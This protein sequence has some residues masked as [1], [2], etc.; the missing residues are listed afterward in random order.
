MPRE[1]DVETYLGACVRTLGGVA[2]KFTSPG[3]RSVPD[4]HV[5]LPGAVEFYVEC[6]APG[7]K[8][9]VLQASEHHR[10]RALGARVYVCNTKED[11]DKAIKAELAL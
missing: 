11:V 4:R 5:R 1:R 2:Y 6:K 8:L 7:G 9:T 3:R 10:L